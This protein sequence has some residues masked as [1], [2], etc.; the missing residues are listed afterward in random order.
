MPVKA[1]VQRFIQNPPPAVSRVLSPPIIG[2]VGGLLLGISPFARLFLGKDAPLGVFTNAVD[3]LS[4][5]YS[6]AALLVLAGSLALPTPP[7]PEP[8]AGAGAAVA[9]TKDRTISGPL[10]VA[11]ICLVRFTLCPALFLTIVLK[12]MSRCVVLFFWG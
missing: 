10:Q 8:A 6:S 1:R 3:T 5:A 11:S 4:K 9:A 12:A 2:C 7:A